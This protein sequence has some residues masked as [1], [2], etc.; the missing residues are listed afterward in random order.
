M[1]K[2]QR[3]LNSQFEKLMYKGYLP[4]KKNTQHKEIRQMRGFKNHL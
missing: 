1:R 4:P 3:V 2:V